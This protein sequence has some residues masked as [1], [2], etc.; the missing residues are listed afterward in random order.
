MVTDIEASE[1]G[2]LIKDGK[3]SLGH[4]FMPMKNK[5]NSGTDI[6]WPEDQALDW[7]QRVLRAGGAWTWNIPFDDRNSQIDPNAMDFAKKIGAQINL[8][9]KD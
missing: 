8:Q 5:W 1:N 4:M 6:V 9:K 2:F 3:A 7:M